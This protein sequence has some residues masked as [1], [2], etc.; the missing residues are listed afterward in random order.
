MQLQRFNQVRGGLE[1]A[2]REMQR[3]GE[4]L[5]KIGELADDEIHFRLNE[6]ASSLEE[7]VDCSW[8]IYAGDLVPLEVPLV[9]AFNTFKI[10]GRPIPLIFSLGHL[11]LKKKFHKNYFYLV[12]K[13]TNCEVFMIFDPVVEYLD[14]VVCDIITFYGIIET[15]SIS[16][17]NGLS[18]ATMTHHH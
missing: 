16:R 11:L 4:L 5:K 6:T 17:E 2:I 12:S 9:L 13:L 1:T 14:N 7:V 10:D 15:T 8:D 18:S 3:T